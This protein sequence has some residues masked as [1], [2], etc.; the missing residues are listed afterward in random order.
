MS[1]N[2]QGMAQ[3][4]TGRV[5]LC[6]DG[7]DCMHPWHGPAPERTATHVGGC[8]SRCEGDTHYLLPRC[9][10]PA[11]DEGATAYHWGNPDGCPR[12]AADHG[13]NVRTDPE[14][15][16]ACIYGCAL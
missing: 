11:R 6:P 13:A 5:T 2:S 16:M 12:D 10:C 15:C 8:N 3:D 9:E 7:T 1:A 14:L 4:P